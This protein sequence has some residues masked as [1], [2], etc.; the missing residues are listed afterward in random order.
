MLLLL[1]AELAELFNGGYAEYTCVPASN[2]IAI[3]TQ[4]L[5]ELLGAMPEMLQTTYGS[6]HKSLKLEKGEA[7]LV[8]GGTTSVELAA[9]AMARSHGA[10]VIATSRKAESKAML[11]ENSAEKVI[12]E[13]GTISEKVKRLYPGG[14]DKVLELIGTATLRD[15]LGCV[16]EGGIACMT[17]IDGNQWSSEMNPMEVIPTGAYL[18]SYAG[19]PAEFLETPLEELAQQGEAGEAGKL[20][21]PIGRVFHIDHIVEAHRLMGLKQ[22]KR[23]DCCIDLINDNLQIQVIE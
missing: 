9:A 18:T 15:S 20:K 12:I 5:W 7:L 10:D 21:V 16:K 3:Q 17:G 4:R 6:L 11:L 22:G 19:G 14:V 23:Q 8:R 2:I 1:W 13:D